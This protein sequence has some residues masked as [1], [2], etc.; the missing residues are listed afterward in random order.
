[1]DTYLLVVWHW[2]SKEFFHVKA[3]VA[4]AF[5]GVGDCDIDVD[6]SIKDEDDGQTGVSGVSKF[7]SP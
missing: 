3:Q 1:M 7:V 4:G 2:R 5:M 6:L